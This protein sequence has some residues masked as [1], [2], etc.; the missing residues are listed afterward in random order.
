MNSN[1]TRRITRHISFTAEEN[2]IIQERAHSVGMEITPFIKQEALHGMAK[3]FQLCALTQHTI[4]IA[5]IAQDIHRVVH[6]PHPDRWLYQADLE[7]IEDKLDNLLE[8]EAA[9][10]TRLRRRMT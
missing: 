7:R 9:I 6:T 4:A 8:I 2:Q 1:T 10:L 5:E 3:G